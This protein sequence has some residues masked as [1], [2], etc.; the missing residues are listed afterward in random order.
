MALFDNPE[1]LEGFT[2]EDFSD[3]MN[4]IADKLNDE[5]WVDDSVTGNGSGSYTFSRYGAKTYVVDNMDLCV[6]S[7]EEF[8]TEPATIAEKFLAEDWEYF[9]VTIRCYLLGAVI[10]E[11]LEEVKEAIDEIETARADA[12]KV[13]ELLAA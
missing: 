8:C 2:A 3:N 11:I 5:L 10:W 7:L 6:E 4:E 13:L 12:V 9:D 1:L